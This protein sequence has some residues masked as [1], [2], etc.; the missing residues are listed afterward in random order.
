[1]ESEA[2]PALS[3]EASWWTPDA[4]E[5][6]LT[7]DQYLLSTPQMLQASPT[8]FAPDWGG[9]Q[10]ELSE[11]EDEA[12]S[13]NVSVAAADEAEVEAA[14]P[15]FERQRLDRSKLREEIL[16]LIE[17][18]IAAPPE[19][20]DATTCPNCGFNEDSG[21]RLCSL[22]HAPMRLSFVPYTGEPQSGEG[23]PSRAT[24]AESD[25]EA[26]AELALVHNL[27]SDAARQL[28]RECK[29]E[30]E[31]KYR[32]RFTYIRRGWKSALA[33]EKK[34]DLKAHERAKEWGFSD[35]VARYDGDE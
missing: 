4:G 12:E 30:S 6:M 10:E 34:Q 11:T 26:L 25:V 27:Q 32:V 3:P 23:Q 1:M 24:Q 9:A 31:E 14:K 33:S 16:E 8:S 17:N 35:V 18:H 15:N 13:Y 2:H 5:P 22:C 21:A 28:V 19:P 29:T 20:A 7:S